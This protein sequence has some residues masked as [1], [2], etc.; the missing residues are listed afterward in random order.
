VNKL[1]EYEALL[2][3]HPLWD[4][5]RQLIKTASVDEVYLT[6]ELIKA[7]SLGSEDDLIWVLDVADEMGIDKEAGLFARALKGLASG[8]GRAGKA[9]GSKSLTGAASNLNLR[10]ARSAQKSMHRMSGAAP[11]LRNLQK[12]QKAKE[13]GRAAV[14][15]GRAQ[16][17]TAQGMSGLR[18][19]AAER[20]GAAKNR[21]T[22]SAPPVSAPAGPGSSQA[23]Q[24][25][26]A[27][28]AR[29]TQSALARMRDRVHA[30]PRGM[31]Y[32][33]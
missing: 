22:P 33:Y 23:M 28:P 2:E 8:V 24:G 17:S 4:D 10:A 18:A 30:R 5:E 19:R 25:A 21:M 9:V 15:Q 14:T 6:G 16:Q 31:A 29:R 3:D 26:S 20:F 32:A 7:A 27:A 1:A 12:Y 13:V 11:T